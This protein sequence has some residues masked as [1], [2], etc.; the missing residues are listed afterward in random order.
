VKKEKGSPSVNLTERGK[1]SFVTTG[2]G[3][4]RFS[5]CTLVSVCG[6]K[7]KSLSADGEE[8]KKKDR[9]RPSSKGKNLLST[10]IVLLVR[11]GM[12]APVLKGEN[13]GEKRRQRGRGNTKKGGEAGRRDL[14]WK[15]KKG[16]KFSPPAPQVQNRLTGETGEHGGK[17]TSERRGRQRVERKKRVKSI[18]RCR[19]G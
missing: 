11:R 8:K 13:R 1:R 5:A 9:V 2:E 12:C 3:G 18:S 15:K 7:K 16:E 4:K 17:W 19:R 14:N 10:A 6:R